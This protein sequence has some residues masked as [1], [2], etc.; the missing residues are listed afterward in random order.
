LT[1]KDLTGRL[2]PSASRSTPRESRSFWGPRQS[3]HESRVPPELDERL[4]QW[5]T[6]FRDR[7]RYSRCGSAEGRFNAHAPGSWDSGWGDV[8]ASGSVPRELKL[9]RV[10]ET[11]ACV[12]G[13]PDKAQRWCVTYA[14]CY[15]HLEK[16]MVLKFLKKHTG[17]RFSWKQYLECLEIGRVRIWAQLTIHSGSGI[18]LS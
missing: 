2:S 12:Q 15:P 3:S 10:L 5:A 18:R 14:Y 7:H 9:S 17:R 1:I 8:E 16:W 6:Y 11:H 13:L 4:N